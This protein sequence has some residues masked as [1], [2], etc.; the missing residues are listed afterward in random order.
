[1]S[2]HNGSLGVGVLAL[3]ASYCVGIA[4]CW[5]GAEKQC[6]GGKPAQ[7]AFRRRMAGGETPT[8]PPPPT[9]QSLSLWTSFPWFREV[10]Q[11]GH[12][13]ALRTLAE[14]APGAGTL[15]KTTSK[16]AQMGCRVG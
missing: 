11:L 1:M 5:H 6:R 15:M 8:P 9:A 16:A 2:V 13:R 4:S 7:T 14:A 3:T 10:T 12:S